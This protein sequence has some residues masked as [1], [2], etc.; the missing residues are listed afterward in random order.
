MY[1][2]L[3][4]L[5]I[6]ATEPCAFKQ[7]LVLSHSV[8]SFFFRLSCSFLH[9]LLHPRP[10]P[11]ANMSLE[12]NGTVLIKRV[13]CTKAK[14]PDNVMFSIRLK[15]MLLCVIG[16]LSMKLKTVIMKDIRENNK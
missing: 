16:Q 14:S 8:L 13:V 2:L 3:L 6:L 7:C 1:F 5:E 10:H 9:S 12:H 4:L 11:S 15:L